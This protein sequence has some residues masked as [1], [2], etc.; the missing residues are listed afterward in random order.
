M[1][2][3]IPVPLAE[4]FDKVSILEIKKDLINDHKKNLLV[5]DELNCLYNIL[6]NKNLINFLE[7]DLY[8]KLKG[9]NKNLWELC[10]IRRQYE[11]EKTFDNNFIEKSRMEY[12]VNDMRAEIKNLINLELD[13]DFIEIKSYSKLSHLNE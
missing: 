12:K 5:Q 6:K 9:I 8:K 2:I 3:E 13:S 4:L 11:Q 7:T 1:K 10:D